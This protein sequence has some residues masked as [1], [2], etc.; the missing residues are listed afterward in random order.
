MGFGNIRMKFYELGNAFHKKTW[1]KIL[2]DIKVP[3]RIDQGSE[4]SPPDF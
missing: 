1:G 4:G 3:E 2:E